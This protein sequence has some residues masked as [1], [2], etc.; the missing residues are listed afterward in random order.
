MVDERLRKVE[1]VPIVRAHKS[2]MVDVPVAEQ[3]RRNGRDAVAIVHESKRTFTITAIEAI[4]ERAVADERRPE[5][6]DA[7]GLPSRLDQL[8]VSGQRGKRPT[9]AVP[10]EKDPAI[11][12]RLQRLAQRLP[13]ILERILEAAVHPLTGHFPRRER[14]LDVRKDVPKRIRLGAAK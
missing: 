5:R 2:L 7:A 11:V 12:Q 4:D 3:P 14:Q 10:C 6:V 9:Q 13:D 1:D 8:A